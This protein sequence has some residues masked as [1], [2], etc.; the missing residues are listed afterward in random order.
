MSGPRLLSRGSRKVD[1]GGIRST[2]CHMPELRF[3]TPAEFEVLR[4]VA[5][6]M[7][8]RGGAFALGAEDVGVAEAIDGLL[9]YFPADLRVGFRRVLW[10]VRISPLLSL[11]F[12]T[13]T[14]M[15]PE[16]RTAYLRGWEESRFYPRRIVITMIKLL[17]TMVFYADPR[18][19]KILG[20][21]TGCVT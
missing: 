16:E 1:C 19:E 5:D 8:P 13:F 3:L 20:Y 2:I 10:F 14:G 17:V 7:V 12:T 18:V 15:S 6:A 11:K 21:S 4:A 9:H